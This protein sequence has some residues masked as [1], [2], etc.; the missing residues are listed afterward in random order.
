MG[1]I[2][3]H[4]PSWKSCQ[5]SS[6]I[7]S[8]LQVGMSFSEL[9]GSRRASKWKRKISLKEELTMGTMALVKSCT[10]IWQEAKSKSSLVGKDCCETLYTG[11]GWGS[12]GQGGIFPSETGAGDGPLPAEHP[13]RLSSFAS[14]IPSRTAP[15]GCQ[16]L[17][18]QLR[19]AV[20]SALGLSHQLCICKP[21]RLAGP[22]LVCRCGTFPG[23]C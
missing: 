13:C 20:P 10:S 21:G 1:E 17:C 14:T 7:S 22:A 9:G 19:N 18:L 3:L 23:L 2:T 16:R 8:C 11:C 4:T 15:G 6:A 12:R 5:S